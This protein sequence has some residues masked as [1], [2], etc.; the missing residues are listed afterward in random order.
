MPRSDYLGDILWRKWIAMKV[1]NDNQNLYDAFVT[2]NFFT[3]LL[4]SYMLPSLV[5]FL[6]INTVRFCLIN[7]ILRI[8][9]YYQFQ[10]SAVILVWKITLED[11][12]TNVW[13]ASITTYVPLVMNP[14][15]QQ[16]N[17]QQSIQCNVFFPEVTLVKTYLLLTQHKTIGLHFLREKSVLC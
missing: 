5:I 14:A 9:W 3:N 4:H 13:Y 7:K 16:T 1:G 15:Q 12:D 2:V 8:I 11:D 6:T 17:I 10:E